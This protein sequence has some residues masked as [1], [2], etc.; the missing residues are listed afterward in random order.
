[1]DEASYI[2]FGSPS[3]RRSSSRHTEGENET[4]RVRATPFSTSI[5]FSRVHTRLEVASF[6]EASIEGTIDAIEL[7][8]DSLKVNDSVSSQ[9]RQS[10]HYQTAVRLR[11]LW[12]VLVKALGFSNAYALASP[13][14]GYLYPAPTS[15]RALFVNKLHLLRIDASTATKQWHREPLRFSSMEP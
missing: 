8:L 14:W 6:F 13:V 3:E 4:F 1:L 15:K 9:L 5:L 10:D 12:E 2:Q 11:S 7:H